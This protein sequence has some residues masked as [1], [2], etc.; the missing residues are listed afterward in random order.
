MQLDLNI[1]N[2]LDQIIDYHGKTHIPAF[3]IPFHFEH[4]K[5]ES[6]KRRE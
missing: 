1:Q 3:D 5:N 4:A 6:T 2:R